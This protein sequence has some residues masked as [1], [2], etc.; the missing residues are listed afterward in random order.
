[1]LES[2][3]GKVIVID[4]EESIRLGCKRILKKAGYD[5][6][7]ASTGEEGLSHIGKDPSSF[8]AVIL[9]L[10]LPGISGMD[11]LKRIKSVDSEIPVVVVTGYATVDKAVEAMKEGAYDFISKP[12]TPDQLRIT[13]ERAAERRRFQ[14]ERELFRKEMERTLRDVI[15]EKSRVKA[16]VNSMMEGLLVTNANGEVVLLNPRARLYLSLGDKECIG[17]KVSDLISG[18]N[19]FLSLY[20][21]TSKIKSGECSSISGECRVG[22]FFLKV[23]ISPF[24]DEKSKEILGYVIVLNDITELK[25]LDMQKSEFVSMVS[26]E[27][28]APV[29]AISQQISVILDG[30]VGE[31]S[32]KQRELL[33]RVKERCAGLLELV[34]DLLDLAKIESGLFTEYREILNLVDIVKKEKEMLEEEAKKKNVTMN[35]S[36]SEGSLLVEADR[37]SVQ[38][39]V[40]NLLSNAIKYNKKGGRVDISLNKTGDFVRLQVADTGVGI[41][42]ED[43]PRIFDKFYRVKTGETR[44][45]VGSGLGLSIVK[46][47][48][49]KLGGRIEVESEL[50]K[51]T[52]FTVLLPLRS[53]NEVNLKSAG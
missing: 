8:Y 35:L 27:L 34:R 50:G 22:D 36:V 23:D 41:P 37:K 17:R 19:E 42:K 11:V 13:V 29:G 16:I 9:D 45:V 18:E 26:H 32:E 31:L 21:E 6:I 28:R 12:F 53:G 38:M 15:F 44:K 46:T 3:K 47:L 25:M 5:V 7:L 52:K 40:M 43:L 4:D 33:E 10:M 49:D 14:L 30:Y 24:R 48:V 39:I 51:G 2:G 20:K 1:M